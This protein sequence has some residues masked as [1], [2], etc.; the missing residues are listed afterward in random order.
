MP[1]AS[2]AAVSALVATVALV[3]AWRVR[4]SQA[5]HMPGF[6]NALDGSGIDFK[7]SFLPAEQGEMFKVNLYDHGCGVAVADY[8]GDGHD[9]VLFLN[10]LGA[11]ALYRNRRDGT[12]QNVTDEAGPLALADRVCV[13]AAFADYDNDGDQ[14]LYITSTRGGNVLFENLGGGRYRDKTDE[15][16]VAL[17]AHSQTPA[18]FDYDNDGYLDL[19][20]TNTARWT[21][22]EFDEQS[23]YFRGAGDL[24]SHVYNAKDRESNVLFRNN[25]DGTFTDVTRESGLLGK[26]WSGDVATID[27][28]DDGNLDLL[29]TNMFGMSQ[30]YRSDGQGHFDDVTRETLHRTSLGAI[31]VKAFDYNNDGRFDLLIADMHSDMWIKAD[32]E[33]R[34]SPHTKYLHI[35]GPDVERFPAKQAEEA[36]FLDRLQL[37]RDDL[38]FGN[39]LFRNEGGGRLS[40]VSDEAGMETFWPWGI[41]VGDF[42][43]DGDEDAYLPSGMGYPYFYYPSSLMMNDGDGTFTDRASEEGIE[44]PPGG[45]YLPQ[46]IVGREAARSSRCACTADFDGDGRLDLMVNNFNDQPYYFKNQFPRRHYVAFRLRGTQ[47]NRDAIGAVVKL[48]SDGRTMIR[49]VQSTG[50][51]L[52]QSS[53]TL[54]FGCGENEAIG[55]VEIRW[56][57]GAR[58]VLESLASDCLHEITE[59]D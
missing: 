47:S 18:F 50:G 38:I 26:G 41:A 45:K 24:W 13:G 17:I 19:F 54:H 5:N 23:S 29:V 42:D 21:T 34:V 35:L 20:V 28:D 46:R 59:P 58:Q 9:D 7:M 43:N 44:P 48:Y 37:N 10:Q 40:E 39:C 1:L 27:F 53:K 22:D 52:S 11:N 3:G 2:L 57:H 4:P 12:F 56:P 36:K 55:R 16:G 25:R 6:S 51:Y 8:D 33:D 49:Q 15:A 32:Q 30:L 31:G 14:D